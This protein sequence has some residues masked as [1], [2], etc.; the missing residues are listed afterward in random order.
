MTSDLTSI[1][2]LVATSAGTFAL[3]R[4]LS[5]NWRAKRRQKDESARRASESRQVRRARERQ[6]RK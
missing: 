2:V 5:R 4:F 1:L 3:A 6:G